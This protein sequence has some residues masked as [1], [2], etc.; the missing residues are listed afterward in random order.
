MAA[1]VALPVSTER[2][3]AGNSEPG[4]GTRCRGCQCKRDADVRRE[5]QS[6]SK[7]WQAKPPGPGPRPGAPEPDGGTAALR[8]ASHAPG[9]GG[10]GSAR[11]AFPTAI[12]AA[13]SAGLGNFK[14]NQ[15]IYCLAT[16]SLQLCT[17]CDWGLR[18]RLSGPCRRH[19]IPASTVGFP[20]AAATIMGSVRPL[21]VS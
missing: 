10:A 17:R 20:F 1:A 4:L 9:G 12:P 2:C 15:I 8:L 21:T 3:A 13:R 11:P 19:R 18:A 7:Q 14:F 16:S 6:Q 5:G